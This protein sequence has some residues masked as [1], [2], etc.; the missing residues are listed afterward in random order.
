MNINAEVIFYGGTHPKAKLWV[1]GKPVEL[2][3]DGTFRYH[4][5]FPDG[6]YSIPIVAESPDGVER[7]SATLQLERG[8][9]RYGRVEATAQPA[10]LGEPFGRN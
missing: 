2:N 8:T 5:K 7:R 9:V 6:N 4:F 10:H 1:D 3:P